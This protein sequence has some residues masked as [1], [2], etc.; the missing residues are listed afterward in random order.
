MRVGAFVIVG[1][2]MVSG[3]I[4]AHS[5][6][7][8]PARQGVWNNIQHVI[9]VMMENHAY[10]NFFGT[11]CL[12]VSSAC[13]HNASGIP[14]GT[15]LP[16]NL[17]N[18]SAG[19]VAPFN[20]TVGNLSSH[21]LNHTYV[22]S[23]M[24]YNNGAM[25][26]FI[27]AENSSLTMGT[28][29]GSVIPV[30]WDIAQKFGLGDNF[31]S[32]V[33]T[34]S[35]TNHWYLIAGQS[36]ALILNAPLVPQG[37]WVG[38]WNAHNYLNE[39]NNTKTVEQELQHRQGVSWAYYDWPLTT[40]SKAINILNANTDGTAYSNWNPLAAKIQSYKGATA[41]HFVARNQF[42]GDLTNGTLPNVSWVIP[43]AKF[44]DHPPANISN[45]ENW[46]ST[47]VNS[48]EA[49]PE[50]NSTALF[51][52]WDDFGG[53]YDHVAP[54]QIDKWGLGFRAPL[55]VI[56]PWTPAGL[57]VHHQLQFE[58]LLAFIEFRWGLGCLDNRDCSAPL[59]TSFFNFHIH[60]APVFFGNATSATYPYS[61]VPS[62]HAY[63]ES[64]S[65]FNSDLSARLN[66]TDAD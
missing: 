50:W 51:L 12:V 43:D 47:I 38:L 46:I 45:G 62:G 16:V 6:N 37:G 61:H 20:F 14:P 21:N 26:G 8:S 36:P 42:F 49:S 23:H 40:Y 15:C 4:A 13:P 54:P 27:P 52:S 34:Y 31:F 22:S 32:S 3:A 55:L 17:T 5:S 11:Y 7:P 59:P 10:D 53:Y 60:R 63:R 66:L 29:N 28:Y 58:S 56:S 19:C 57:V 39:A 64:V 25:N 24:S 48:V 30:Y 65:N 1:L 41:N 18:A 35:I 9:V 44:S 2:L 33:L